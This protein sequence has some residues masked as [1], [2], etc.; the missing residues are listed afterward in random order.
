V[1]VIERRRKE[2][3]TSSGELEEVAATKSEPSVWRVLD[4]VVTEAVVQVWRSDED[5]M[6]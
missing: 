5:W 1:S 3:E 4:W 6:V 2:A